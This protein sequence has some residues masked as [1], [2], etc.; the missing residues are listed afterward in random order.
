MT[1]TFL[2]L[3][4]VEGTSRWGS[5]LRCGC[6]TRAA[7]WLR[8][9]LMAAGALAAVV[10]V[11]GGAAAQIQA[12]T[13]GTR[14]PEERVRAH[15]AALAHDSLRGRRTG[16]EGARTA[17]RYLAAELE[18]YG[19]EPAGDDGYFQTVPLV[20]TR[21]G[22]RERL[23]LAGPASGGER[24]RGLNVVGLVRGAGDGAREAVVVGAHYDHLG[25]GAAVAGDSIYNGADDD[26]SGV[27]A[28]LE[29]ARAVAEGERPRRTVVFLFSTAEEQGLLGTRWYLEHPV[30]PLERTVANLQVEMIGRP[31]SLAGGRGRVWLTGFE[32]ST[33]GDLLS[34]GGVPVVADPRPEQGFFFRSDNIAFAR[35]G[36]PAHT[37]SSYG[38]HRDYHRPSDEVDRVDGTHFARAVEAVVRAVE[39]LAHGPAPRWRPGGRPESEDP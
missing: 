3:P 39:V 25:V 16:T 19:L 26:A 20:R 28:V 27:V 36:V 18:R 7:S 38:M 23:R 6:R 13:A 24:L 9:G 31:D 33:M 35:R 8:C 29:A 15:L 10:V 17:A 34:Q 21:E 12:P 1:P 4:A 11:A 14:I 22:G 30:V 32:R 37:L 2:S 5:D